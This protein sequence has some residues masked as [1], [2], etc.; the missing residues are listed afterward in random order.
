MEAKF[1]AVVRRKTKIITPILDTQG[2]PV[3]DGKGKAKQEEIDTEITDDPVMDD[4]GNPI[5]AGSAEG[6]LRAVFGRWK[7]DTNTEI[8]QVW[9]RKTE[10]VQ[11][12][13]GDQLKVQART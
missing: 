11:T 1:G 6:V 9:V 7:D 5:E 3:F 8:L 10:T 12:L 13:T 4:G 2:K